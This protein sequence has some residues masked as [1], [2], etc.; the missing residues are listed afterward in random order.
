LK[1]FMPADYPTLTRK[2]LWPGIVIATILA[3]AALTLRY[4]G[5]LWICSCGQLLF[6]AGEVCSS[7]NSQHFL[8]P[9]SFTH[10][11]HGMA[12]YGLLWL[13]VPKIPLSWRLCLALLMEAV[14]E[15]AENTNYV[16]QL[17]R[18]T[19]A[20]LGYQGDTVVNALGDIVTCGIGFMIARWL[21][22]WRSLALFAVTEAVL[23]VWIRDSLTLEVLMLIYP[24][25]A[26]KAWQ[27]CP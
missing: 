25:S 12:L 3:V 2:G 24:I 5:R 15:V 27:L 16:I 22:L 17:Y 20:A 6:W 21:G 9:Y 18:E 26:I 19:T 8:D 1:K 13:L 10:I 11:L 14:W 7:H 4:L 23:I